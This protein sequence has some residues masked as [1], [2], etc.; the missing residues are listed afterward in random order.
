MAAAVRERSQRLWRWGFWSLLSL[1]ALARL[2]LA[3]TVGLGVDESHYVLYGR[4]PDWGYVDH[5]P[6]VAWMTYLGTLI[7]KSLFFYRLGPILCN[8]FS[9]VLL[10]RLALRLWGS[11]MIAFGA[12]AVLLLLP[13]QHLLTTALLPDAGLNLFWCATLLSFRHSI[14]SG[15]W[16]SWLAT[17]VFLGG[18]LL[19]KYHA[20]LLPLCLGGYLLT[21]A[22]HRRWLKK[23]QPYAAAL[24]ALAVFSP[25]LIWNAQN[26]WISYRYQLGRAGSGGFE[27]GDAL[28]A[29]GGQFAAWSPL[30]FALLIASFVTVLRKSSKS[31]SECFALWISLPVF[32]FFI[33]IGFFGKVL[34]HWTSPGWWGGS[35]L[36]AAVTLSKTAAGGAVAARWRRAAIAAAAVGLLMTIGI[37]AAL[38]QPFVKPVYTL[39]R[40]ASLE[41]S[42]RLPAVEPLPPYEAKFDVTNELFGWRA[43]AE[44]VRAALQRMPRQRHTFIFSHRFFTVSQ[45]AVHLPPETVVTTLGRRIDQYRIWFNPAAHL[46][47]DALF[48]DVDRRRQG[49]DRYSPLFE[50]VDPAPQVITVTRNGERIREIRLYRYYG[51][52]GGYQ[53]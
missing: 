19:S 53:R 38:F 26:G 40:S 37:Y 49:P 24:A 14:G 20:A 4:R 46:G 35:L 1:T 43:A 34:P 22:K 21:A 11:E 17:G 6:I 18:A 30:I 3:G 48:V 42:R 9:I 10:R 16:R 13:Y 31:D 7:C 12:L 52:R 27:L 5:P 8:L 45:L 2:A 33:F 44:E 47:W 51:Y 23:P 41:L 50:R 29:I 36:L 39:L 25:N 15:R 32:A 28:T